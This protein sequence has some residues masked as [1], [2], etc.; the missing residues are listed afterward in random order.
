MA[1]RAGIGIAACPL[2]WKDHR[3]FEVLHCRYLKSYITIPST[4]PFF[5]PQ[6]SQQIH[7]GQGT[8]CPTSVT[9]PVWCIVQQRARLWVGAAPGL[10]RQHGCGGLSSPY[11]SATC[12][13]PRQ[14]L[15]TISDPNAKLVEREIKRPLN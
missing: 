14:G 5:L 2:L 8:T 7:Q 6:H 1:R 10:P 13:P 4:Q 9:R 12:N 15:E 3:V 11:L